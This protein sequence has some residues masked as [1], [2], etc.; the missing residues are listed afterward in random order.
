MTEFEPLHTQIQKTIQTMVGTIFLEDPSGFP[1]KES[2]LYH[3]SKEG[4]LLWRAEKPEP[5]GLY[6]RVMLNT[7]G[8]SLSAYT[9]TGKACEIDLYTG[10]LISQAK[11]M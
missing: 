8:N 9:I 4:K 6:N 1:I 10:K 11:I 2:N 7:D 3:V 5:T